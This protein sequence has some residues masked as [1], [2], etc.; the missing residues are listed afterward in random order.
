MRVWNVIS[1]RDWSNQGTTCA[2]AARQRGR[3][4]SFTICPMLFQSAIFQFGDNGTKWHCREGELRGYD[5]MV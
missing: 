3:V 5:A 4:K 1:W 2:D